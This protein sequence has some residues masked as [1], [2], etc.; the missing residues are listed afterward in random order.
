MTMFRPVKFGKYLLV[1]KIARGGM[2]EIYL[3]KL[4]GAEGFEKD[5][6]IKMILPEWSSNRSFLTML[7]DE[8]KLA[9]RLNHANIVP[10]FELGQEGDKYYIA[11]EY[12]DGVDLRRL[13]SRMHDDEKILP[14]HLSIY[15]IIRVLEGLSYAHNKKD[16]E[17]NNLNIIHRDI[18]PQN[19]LISFDG[20]VKLTDFGIAKATLSSTETASGVHKGKYSYMSPEQANLEEVGQPTDIFST[21]IILYEL[22]TGRRLFGGGS[23]IQTLDRIRKTEVSFSSEEKKRLPAQ[24]VRIIS[25]MLAQEIGK[26]F[27]S[28]SDIC[29]ELFKFSI[30]SDL[31]C[32]REDLSSFMRESFCDEILEKK[33]RADERRPLEKT[34]SYLPPD[35]GAHVLV[36]SAEVPTM[37]AAPKARRGIV[38]SIRE[39]MGSRRS[40]FGVI[41][42][43]TTI[44]L[45][46][47][48]FFYLQGYSPPAKET[49]EGRPAEKRGPPSPPKPGAVSLRGPPPAERI[50]EGPAELTVM[51]IPWGTVYVDGRRLGDSPI[52]RHR[53]MSGQHS[54]HVRYAP[55]NLT[56]NSQVMIRPDQH[57]K[58]LANFEEGSRGIRCR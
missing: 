36:G 57:M 5:L 16:N 9:V 51:V 54:V 12:V 8:A 23:D 15:I 19:I 38:G 24:L 43:V 17:G 27:K 4:Y 47:G 3:A 7:I 26:R 56:L 58:C 18:S 50:E 44:L 2:A 6:V 29:K 20:A 34:P 48:L 41:G 32:D 40:L 22:V 49:D 42:A 55:E 30:E 35:E 46:A 21:G 33:K 11:M 37:G 45:A 31:S 28:A 14:L 1:D 53:L 39:R 13:W 52:Q 25:K 10:V